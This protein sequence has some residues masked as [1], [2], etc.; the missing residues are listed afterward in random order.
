MNNVTFSAILDWLDSHRVACF[1]IYVAI[2]TLVTMI[3]MDRLDLSWRRVAE[4]VSRTA[5]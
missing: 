2:I 5:K 1:I 4:L 3:L